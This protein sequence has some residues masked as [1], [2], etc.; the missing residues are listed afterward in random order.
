MLTDGGNDGLRD[1]GSST[2]SQPILGDGDDRALGRGR[3]SDGLALRLIKLF[4]RVSSS[5]H[6]L[7]LPQAHL[8]TAPPFPVDWPVST[9]H[10]S[11]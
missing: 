11:C 10:T 9:Q 8:G 4:C 6:L 5:L 2:T 1:T 3:H 7:D